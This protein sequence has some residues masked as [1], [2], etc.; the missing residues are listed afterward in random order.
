M[1]AAQDFSP[2]TLER[3]QLRVWAGLST[4]A[5]IAFFEEIIDL[6]WRSGAL[7]PER[8]AMRDKTNNDEDPR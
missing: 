3:E 6:A 7:A 5:K 1:S 2:E 8:L 4:E